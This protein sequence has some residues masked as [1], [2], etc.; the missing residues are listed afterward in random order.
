MSLLSIIAVT[1]KINHCHY[2]NDS[3]LFGGKDVIYRCFHKAY[4]LT[5]RIF[6]ADGLVFKVY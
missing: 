4:V 1:A 6:H 2:L 5:Y 3:L